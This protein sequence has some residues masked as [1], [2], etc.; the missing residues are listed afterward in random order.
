MELEMKLEHEVSFRWLIFFA[1]PTIFS[2]IFENIYS[3]IDGIFIARFV[4]TD[5]LSAINIVMPMIGL[6][7]ALGMMFG[8][9]GNALVAKKIGMG[10]LEEAREDFSLLI[11]VAFGICIVLAALCFVFLDP[12]CRFLGSDEALLH[13]CREY[14]IP[15]LIMLPFAAFG[16]VFHL[17]FITVGKAGL[18]AFLAVLGG[19]LNIVLDWL[20]ITVFHWG[21][22]GA[23]IATSI[24]YAVQSLVGAVWFCVNRKQV[25]YIVRP[26]WRSKA[27]V[28]SCINGSS[29]MVSVL[30]FSVITILFNRILMD[31]GGS[32]GV[33]SL[34]IIWYAQGL[35]GGLFRG[36]IN[37][38]SS[39][40]SYNLGK[41]D[42]LRLSK[43]FSISVWT[44]LG[45]SAVVTAISY[46]FGG[47]VV[48]F[49]AK[50]NAHVAQV[51]LHGFRIVAISF[52]MMAFNVFASG[53][54]TALNDGK[55][56]AILSFC[57][58]MLFMVVPVLILPKFFEMDGVWMALTVGEL[59]SLVMAVFYFIKY[60]DMWRAPSAAE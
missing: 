8:T 37:G 58:T 54:F 39:V 31:I 36:Y 30:A 11:A 5:A 23:A 33:A 2:S 13:Y 42:K 22:A 50:G 15:V 41:G 49:F 59:L 34:T 21:L 43:A 10:R 35:F 27:I 4:D 25:L 45:T 14:M 53:W 46:I 9:G 32:D 18:G 17:S 44:L 16:M 60:R 52:A 56:S 1:L 48:D 38:I 47:A 19:V 40:V 26:K 7:L 12:L 6:S 29:E 51:A 20:F 55:T 3:T 28:D 24:G 57:R